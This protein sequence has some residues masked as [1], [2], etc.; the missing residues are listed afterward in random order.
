MAGGSWE[1]GH[2][3]QILVLLYIYANT[4]NT[5][6]CLSVLLKVSEKNFTA[7]RPSLLSPAVLQISV[8]QHGAYMRLQSMARVESAPR[9]VFTFAN[10][11]FKGMA[12]W[13]PAISWNSTSYAIW[14]RVK[15]PKIWLPG[16]FARPG[17]LFLSIAI[18]GSWGQDQLSSRRLCQLIAA[19][20]CILK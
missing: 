16:N 10:V 13:P 9:I 6:F 12:S 4:V 8:W 7:E 3:Y 15:Q 1:G 2:L 18:L 17:G 14:E 20:Q 11:V 19:N 5:C